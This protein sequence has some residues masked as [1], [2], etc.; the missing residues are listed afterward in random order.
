MG[1]PES[2]LRASGGEPYGLL[3][4]SVKMWY[5]PCERGVNRGMPD[6][7]FCLQGIPCVRR[8]EPSPLRETDVLTKYSLHAQG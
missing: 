3:R 7:H 2:I 4:Q 6:L 5:S 1:H 8:G